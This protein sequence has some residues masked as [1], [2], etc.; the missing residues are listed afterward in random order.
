MNRVV[1]AYRY[2]S[3][4]ALPDDTTPCND[5]GFP[6]YERMGS[7]WLADDDL[8]WRIVSDDSIVLCPGCF[9]TRA[10]LAGVPMHW[11]AVREGETPSEHTNTQH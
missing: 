6:Y 10:H 7:Y 2:Q 8:W 4:S 5:C 11:R 9:A 3:A 1:P